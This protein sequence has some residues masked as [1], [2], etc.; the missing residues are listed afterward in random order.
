MSRGID[1]LPHVM[2]VPVS[3][4][5]DTAND[6]DSLLLEFRKEFPNCPVGRPGRFFDIVQRIAAPTQP[7]TIGHARLAG[8]PLQSYRR[9][10]WQARIR[11]AE[12]S[13]SG[14][15]FLDEFMQEFMTGE[16]KFPNLIPSSLTVD[17]YDLWFVYL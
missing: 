12:G 11:N 4:H 6:A 9:R 5:M 3:L 10:V 16:R 7:S 8:S 15:L 17:L 1:Y 14:L 2:Q 13:A